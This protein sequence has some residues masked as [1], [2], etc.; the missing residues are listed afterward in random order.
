MIL[1]LSYISFSHLRKINELFY[2][3]SKE[4]KNPKRKD[5][6]SHTCYVDINC[7]ESSERHC[8][9]ILSSNPEIEKGRSLVVQRLGHQNGRG[10]VFAVRGEVETN[11]H[12]GFGDHPILQVVR[13]PWVTQLRCRL[14]CLNNM[15]S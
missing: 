7:S 8:S 6:K 13:H 3:N 5:I 12:V 1:W 11:W 4:Q 14:D 9:N 2:T 15:R 10:A